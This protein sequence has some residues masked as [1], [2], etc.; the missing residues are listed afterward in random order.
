MFAFDHSFYRFH[1][2]YVVFSRNFDR[3]D[4]PSRNL[5]LT[6]NLKEPGNRAQMHKYA[7]FMVEDLGKFLSKL[8]LTHFKFEFWRAY[9]QLSAIEM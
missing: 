8:N 5:I 3:Y 1:L 6:E 2:K 9:K 4:L 7:I